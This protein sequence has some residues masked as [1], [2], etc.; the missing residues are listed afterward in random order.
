MLATLYTTSTPYPTFQ[1]IADRM[2]AL[3]SLFPTTERRA[4]NLSGIEKGENIS[5]CERSG[6]LAFSARKPISFR[7]VQRVTAPHGRIGIGRF[8]GG[9]RM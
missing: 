1:K 2:P 7:A 8:H 6:W 4:F 3:D 9:L 5:F